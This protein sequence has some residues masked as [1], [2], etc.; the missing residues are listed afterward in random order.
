MMLKSPVSNEDLPSLGGMHQ[1]E[2]ILSIVKNESVYKKRLTDLK[3]KRDELLELISTVGSVNAIHEIREQA[4]QEKLKI[5]AELDALRDKKEAA[6]AV[7][8][9][10]HVRAR[11]IEADAA[12]RAREQKNVLDLREKEV[13]VNREQLNDREKEVRKSEER[14]RG[15]ELAVG[16]ELKRLEQLQESANNARKD[17]EDRRQQIEKAIAG[18]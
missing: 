6:D 13:Y 14:L 3:K 10:A 1:L 15:S 9:E 11:A 5:T 12:S 16:A 8:S 4:K 7:I 18:V 2:S 17:Y